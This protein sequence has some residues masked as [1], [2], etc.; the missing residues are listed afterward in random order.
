M[1]I[2]S[3]LVILAREYLHIARSSDIDPKQFVVCSYLNVLML[4]PISIQA[5]PSEFDEA[6]RQES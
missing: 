4:S 6:H 3:H 1:L 5:N 2:G